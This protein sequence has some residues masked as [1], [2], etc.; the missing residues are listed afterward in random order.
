V[1]KILSDLKL[2]GEN[3][4]PRGKLIKRTKG[5]RTPFYRL[6]VDQFRIFYEI[7]PKKIVIL[8]II[9]K[10]VADRFIKRLWASLTSFYGDS[11]KNSWPPKVLNVSSPPSSVRMSRVTAASW[12]RMRKEPSPLSNPEIT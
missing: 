10:K 9:G 4:F 6:R 3:P 8:R 12:A 1:T 5:K 2:L 7:Q 11:G